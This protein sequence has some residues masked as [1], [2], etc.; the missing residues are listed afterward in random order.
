MPR[1]GNI[2]MTVDTHCQITFISTWTIQQLHKVSMFRTELIITLSHLHL[3]PLPSSSLSVIGKGR[4][5]SPSITD[6]RPFPYHLSLTFALKELSHTPVHSVPSHSQHPSSSQGREAA[7]PWLCAWNSVSLPVLR[8][9][10]CSRKDTGL[11]TEAFVYLKAA[12]KVVLTSSH[13]KKIKTN[14]EVMDVIWS[15][16]G[17]HF[18]TYTSTKSSCCAP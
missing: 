5:S 13:H 3:S 18:I 4:C 2:F 12:K 7:A 17:D 6:S 1:S 9:S 16:C 11:E 14:C 15:Y 10:I 8:A